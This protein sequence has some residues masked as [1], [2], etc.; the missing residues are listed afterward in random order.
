MR[1]RETRWGK[2]APLFLVDE[3]F[4]DAVAKHSW[5][6]VSGGRYLAAG[7][8]LGGKRR[9]VMLHRFV[10]LLKHG[11]CPEIIDHIN[12]C[13]YDCRLE[14]L[15]A[16]DASLSNRNRDHCRGPNPPGVVRVPHAKSRPFQAKVYRGGG[17]H[18]LGCFETSEAA[19]WAVANARLSVAH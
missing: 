17:A 11:D 14:N 9:M 19:S 3:E 13:R 16:A 12:R 6:P 5:V 8:R 1:G 7:M 15:R 10:W 18:H 4:V 2:V